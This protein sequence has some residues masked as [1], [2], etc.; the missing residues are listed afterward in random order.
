[1]AICAWWVRNLLALHL[2]RCLLPW[3]WELWRPGPWSELV[4]ARC[5]SARDCK[6]DP[7]AS[8]S[9]P[10]YHSP[11]SF[12]TALDAK[13]ECQS[14]QECVDLVHGTSSWY[15]HLL[16]NHRWLVAYLTFLYFFLYIIN[17]FNSSVYTFSLNKWVTL[18]AR[19]ILSQ[20]ALFHSE[21]IQFL[22]L[23]IH[24]LRCASQHHIDL[25]HVVDTTW[26]QVTLLSKQSFVTQI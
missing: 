22:A 10:P 24:L 16:N 12:S 6:R 21:L 7:A 15:P 14:R 8:L 11:T 2:R 19:H 17:C 20:A 23:F 1:M 5:G 18:L 13:E 9:L 25:F 4:L 3:Q 26:E